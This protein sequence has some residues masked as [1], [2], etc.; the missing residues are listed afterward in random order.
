MRLCN[1]KGAVAVLVSVMMVLIIVCV[2]FVTDMG[3][4]HNTKVE[5]Q[6][7]VDAAALAA[8]RQLD[9]GTDMVQNAY[10]AATVTAAANDVTIET[11]ND[12]SDDCTT[13]PDSSCTGTWAKNDL[14]TSAADRFTPD[15]DFPDAV[16]V[17]A[18]L[19]VNPTFSGLFTG[20]TEVTADA[21]AVAAP[22][23]PV[24][25]LAI[26]TC[27]PS[28]DM[29]DNLGSWPPANVCGISDYAFA[30]DQDDTAAWT[31]LTYNASGNEIANLMTSVEGRIRFNNVIFGANIP[32]DGLENSP[33]DTTL[34]IGFN[35]NYEGCPDNNGSFPNED[36]I[37]CGLGRITGEDLAPPDQFSPP[38]SPVP[39]G[40][41]NTTYGEPAPSGFDPLTGYGN[42]D[43]TLPRWYNLHDEDPP[44]FDEEDHFTRVWSQ[45]GILVIRDADPNDGLDNPEP[46]ADFLQRMYDLANCPVGDLSCRPYDD[47]RFLDGNLIHEPI[48]AFNTNLMNSDFGPAIQAFLA[49]PA[50]DDYYWP[51]YLEVMKHAG[52]PKVTLVNGDVAS[53]MHGFMENENAFDG[54]NLRGTENEPFP[55]KKT[56]RVNAPVIFA[57]ACERW[58]AVGNPGTD[59]GYRYIGL[60]KFL[61]TRTWIQSGGYSSYDCGEDSEV[62]EWE[63]GHGCDQSSYDPG[64]NGNLFSVP[65]SVSPSLKALEGLS[66]VPLDADEDD[67][68][69]LLEVYLVE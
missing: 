21:I 68:G 46:T 34:P 16:L 18:K 54:T 4:I 67:V 59:P 42:D 31:G 64:L 36:D 65:V 39:P 10:D 3:Q 37:K 33:V 32:G 35:P 29:L 49:D 48:G 6:E 23:L 38:S 53:A 2:A 25:P 58:K 44:V 8:A 50:H 63:S 15:D 9:G 11:F 14:G 19:T 20:G 47:D 57:G 69:A 40:P 51:D 66:L 43:G 61:L 27:V 52:Y 28:E 41:L 30:N 60:S 17:R 26:I 56:L 62:V 24:L 22:Q 12:T 5:L 7:A 13:N 1:E 55:D 45:D